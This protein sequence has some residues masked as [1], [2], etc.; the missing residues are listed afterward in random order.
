[1]PSLFTEDTYE[2]AI[3]ELFEN[4]GY[5]HLYAPDWIVIT[6]VLCW[7]LNSETAWYVLIVVCL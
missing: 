4:M 1:M 3:I 6:A 7:M 2:H 5:D